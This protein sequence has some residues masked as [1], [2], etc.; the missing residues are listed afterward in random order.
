MKNINEE[1][2]S[3]TKITVSRICDLNLPDSVIDQAVKSFK[4]KVN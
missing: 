4:E 1:I 3:I 2:I